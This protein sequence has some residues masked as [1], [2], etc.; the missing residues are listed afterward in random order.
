MKRQ[1]VCSLMILAMVSITCHNVEAP[2]QKNISNTL[3]PN[4]AIGIFT[5][6]D[7][8]EHDVSVFHPSETIYLYLHLKNTTPDTITY[9]NIQAVPQVSYELSNDSISYLVPGYGGWLLVQQSI[10]PGDSLV[11][12]W[13]VTQSLSLGQWHVRLRYPSINDTN[14][15]KVPSII[16]LSIIQ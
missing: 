1:I 14:A 11:R 4:P 5:T 16:S 3:P 7:T 13:A 12:S 10:L 8:L 9:T 6:R 15:V 2:N